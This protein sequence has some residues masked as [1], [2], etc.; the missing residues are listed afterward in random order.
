EPRAHSQEHEEEE[1]MSTPQTTD[2]VKTA[3][4][5]VYNWNYAPEIDQLRNL[6][7]NALERQWIGARDL[8]WSQP[9][10][11]QAVSRSFN[12]WGTPLDQPDFWATLPAETRWEISRRSAAF[13]LSNFLHG[14]QGAL[15]I[16]GQLVNAVPHMDGKFYAATQTL[17]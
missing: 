5:A 11:R 13:M 14:E 9:V 6:Y 15:F 10:D 12:T 1:P 2:G 16:A 17:D 7:A 4:R 8:D 3:L